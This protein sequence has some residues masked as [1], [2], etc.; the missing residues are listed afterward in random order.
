MSTVKPWNTETIK[1]RVVLVWESGA[2]AMAT[3]I[4]MTGLPFLKNMTPPVGGKSVEE[5]KEIVKLAGALL[6]LKRIVMVKGALKTKEAGVKA[7]VVSNRGGRVLDQCLSVAEAL[8]AVVE[9]VDQETMVLMDDGIRSG[10]DVFKVLAMGASGVLIVRLLVTVACGGG[11]E[12]VAAYIKRLSDE[13]A[14]TTAM[15]GTHTIG[16]IARDMI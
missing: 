7:I 2:F 5:I 8:P 14:D 6:I 11:A 3:G 16:E 4:D 9:T 15:R 10:V 13:L 12:D 1:E